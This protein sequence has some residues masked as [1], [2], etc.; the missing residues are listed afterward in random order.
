MNIEKSERLIIWSGLGME[1]VCNK[2]DQRH[3]FSYSCV[4]SMSLVYVHSDSKQD[5]LIVIVG[6]I[7]C[8]LIN[9]PSI[10]K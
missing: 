10:S 4:Q 1:G 6:W 3:S 9:I 5:S 2:Q 7:H 8:H